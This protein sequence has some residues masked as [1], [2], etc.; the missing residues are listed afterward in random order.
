[1]K[2]AKLLLTVMVVLGTMMFASIANA[3]EVDSSGEPD[4]LAEKVEEATVPLAQNEKGTDSGDVFIQ[5]DSDAV[6]EHG[7]DV[8]K[9]YYKNPGTSNMGVKVEL[10]IFDNRAYE[11]FGTTFKSKD[12]LNDLVM[13]GFAAM[14]NG[15]PD[16]ATR[17][18]LFVKGITKDNN[19][20]YPLDYAGLIDVLVE[21]DFLGFSKEDWASINRGNIKDLSEYQKLMIAQFGDYTFDRDGFVSIGETGI[22]NPGYMITSMQLHPVGEDDFVLPAGEYNAQFHIVGYDT[23]K[24]DFSDL[25]INMPVVLH[26]MG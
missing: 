17:D 19:F 5:W 3:M 14:Q 11:Y 6:A 7:D 23:G 20:D 26:I 10:V 18:M 1:M 22:I 9:I 4:P 15:I 21:N 8:A 24:E 13:Q 12:E 25:K 2:R 16:I